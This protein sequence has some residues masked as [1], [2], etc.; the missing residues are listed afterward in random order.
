MMYLAFDT[1]T[2]GITEKCNVLT[3][4]FII[5][6]EN[7]AE[8]GSKGFK[9]TYPNYHVYTKALEINGIDLIKHSN[10]GITVENVNEELKKF[11][12]DYPVYTALGHNIDFDIRMLEANNIK[13]RQYL[14]SSNVDTLEIC[15]KFK[16]SGIISKN[17]SLSLSKICYALSIQVEDTELHTAEYD[18][19]L[20][21]ELYK[22]LLSQI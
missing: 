5:L 18:I 22:E 7:L 15:Q 17:Q 8:I 20:T 12:I 14:T 21:L 3:V 11:L 9:V 19:R 13:I 10:E 6:D 2:T 1:E 16:S 4:H